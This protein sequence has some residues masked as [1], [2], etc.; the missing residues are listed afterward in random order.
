MS[1]K[2]RWAVVFDFDGTLT[3]KG[4]SL[5]A[6][7]D[8]FGLSPEGREAQQKIHGQL[9]HKATAGNLTPEEDL[10]WLEESIKNYIRYGLTYEKARAVLAAVPLRE[11][12]LDCLRLLWQEQV[13]VAIISYGIR[14][15]IKMVLRH[16]GPAAPGFVDRIYAAQLTTDPNTNHFV[17]YDAETFVLQS[18]KD[19]WSRKFAD[20]YDIPYDHILAVGD[21]GGDKLLGYLR[22]N[23]LVIAKDKTE[24]AK[25]E[26]FAGDVAITD[27]FDPVTVW[28]RMKMGI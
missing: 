12:V 13:P 18:T 4:K 2:D 22:R 11:G 16:H 5:F 28:L 20:L 9:I 1:A 19:V 26:P 8:E 27:G 24:A 15:F 10:Y 25:L 21:S 7:I 3:P 6:T 14:P 17:G 23:R